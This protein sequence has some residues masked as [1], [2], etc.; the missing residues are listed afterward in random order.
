MNR[1]RFLA[2]AAGAALVPAIPSAAAPVADSVK[3]SRARVAI[4]AVRSADMRMLRQFVEMN[5]LSAEL[6]HMY[7]ACAAGL[8]IPYEQVQADAAALIRRSFVD[9]VRT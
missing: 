8:G 5:R 7:R 9:P 6:E 3:W 4:P 1:R 2:V